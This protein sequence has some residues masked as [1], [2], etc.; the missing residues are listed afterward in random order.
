MSLPLCF[1]WSSLSSAGNVFPKT[2]VKLRG[3][4]RDSS[5]CICQTLTQDITPR[6]IQVLNI[7]QTFICAKP[8]GVVTL[9]EEQG[10][11]GAGGG[12]LSWRLKTPSTL[13]L[14]SAEHINPD[15][16][17]FSSQALGLTT[18]CYTSHCGDWCINTHSYKQTQNIQTHTSCLRHT[19]ITDRILFLSH[20]HTFLTQL[21]TAWRFIGVLGQI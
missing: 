10:A 15:Q 7:T 11:A 19:C 9:T 6:N 18:K 12:D 3:K 1:S 8:P 4:S 2:A 5:T 20:A 13:L 16:L 17:H 21:L 14:S